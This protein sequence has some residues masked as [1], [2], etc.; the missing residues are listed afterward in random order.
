MLHL[1]SETCIY[2]PLP[3]ECFCQITG[4]QL[5]YM[6]APK[7]LPSVEKMNV[8]APRETG[9]P[10]VERPALKRKGED[11]EPSARPTKRLK[12]ANSVVSDVLLSKAPKKRAVKPKTWVRSILN[13]S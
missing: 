13:V 1:L 4:P 7:S 3:N 2:V 6:A 11:A 12:T 9:A 10:V 8:D 5:I